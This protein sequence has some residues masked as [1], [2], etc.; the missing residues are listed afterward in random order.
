MSDQPELLIATDA[1]A[2]AALAAETFA[3]LARDSVESHGV[4]R[5]ALS[6]GNTPRLLFDRLASPSFLHEIDWGRSQVFFSDERFVPPES[7]E[8]NYHTAKESLFSR[9]PTPPSA[10]H[11]VPTIGLDP[12]EAAVEYQ[13]SIE[14]ILGPGSDS[15]PRFDLI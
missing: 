13:R 10:I 14:N 8:S 5:V 7:A 6:G 9:V 12:E 2:L 3:G 1:P 4:F 15:I 11:H